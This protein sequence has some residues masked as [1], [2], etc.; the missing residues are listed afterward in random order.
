MQQALCG[1]LQCTTRSLGDKL[2]AWPGLVPVL[3]K[4]VRLSLAAV[5]PG[6]NARLNDAAR[7]QLVALKNRLQEQAQSMVSRMTTP[8]PM[9][10]AAAATP[11]APPA[12]SALSPPSQPQL[13]A[14]LQPGFRSGA[15]PPPASG[16]SGPSEAAPSTAEPCG[17]DRGFDTRTCGFVDS[18]ETTHGLTTEELREKLA[19][20]G[21]GLRAATASD[22]R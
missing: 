13:P 19:A 2:R 10:P 21:V 20:T 7:A 11:P 9:A 18:Q 14:S 16:D 5:P 15:P 17:G 8:T 22:L 1:A 4:S 3:L 6:G 12:L